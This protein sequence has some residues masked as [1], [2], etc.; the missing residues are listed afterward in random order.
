VVENSEKG[1]GKMPGAH[2]W[3]PNWNI[4]GPLGKGGQGFTKRVEST[5]DRC[6]GVLKTLRFDRDPQARQRMYR[7]VVSLETLSNVQAHVSRVLDHNTAQYASNVKLY[8]VTEYISGATLQETI[9]NRGR[10]SLDVSTKLIREICKVVETAHKEGVQHRDLKPDNIIVR[11]LE[12]NDVVIIDFGLAFNAS[13]ESL[14]ATDQTIRNK[15]LDLP[16]NVVP[17]GSRRDPRSDI[18]AIC[19][20]LYFCLTGHVPGQLHGPDGRLPHMRDGYSL[21]EAVIGDG[22]LEQLGLLFTRGF[23]PNIQNR[24]QSVPELVERL[25]YLSTA[26]GSNRP[27][28]DPKIVAGRASAVLR[29]RDRKTQLQE[30][31]TNASKLL[32]EIRRS[33]TT[34][35][36]QLGR[37]R[38][39]IG[40]G[41]TEDA[42]PADMELVGAQ[43]IWIYLS[44]A[45][46]PVQRSVLYQVASQGEQCVLLRRT[47]KQD[48]ANENPVPASAWQ[49]VFWY[50]S[51]QIPDRD[52][53][54]Q[55][56]EQWI[57]SAIESIKVQ[58]LAV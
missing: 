9:R 15:F 23:S 50:A 36:D 40:S 45:H 14:T 57:N 21:G 7:E 42:L 44:A 26:A 22:R 1:R 6:E 5:S 53:A 52:T 54:I 11:D 34:F 2:P 47:Y 56:V 20:L 19:G 37:F 24:F 3:E 35:A 28:E 29:E 30:F 33:A 32:D 12:S 38:L 39:Q 41:L 55:D 58:I 16:E 43:G 25:D 48:K 10:L 8:V 27:I 31:G 17:G 13:D 46:H 4:I 18:T 49:T 51:E